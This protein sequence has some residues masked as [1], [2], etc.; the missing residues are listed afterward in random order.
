VFQI[1]VL[2]TFVDATLEFG[3]GRQSN[4]FPGHRQ[5]FAW[6]SVSPLRLLKH[7]TLEVHTP[8]PRKARSTGGYDQTWWE[9]GES[10]SAAFGIFKRLLQT[11]AL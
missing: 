4:S 8:E 6:P 3:R 5:T 11:R 7:K 1:P 2:L 10:G 9:R